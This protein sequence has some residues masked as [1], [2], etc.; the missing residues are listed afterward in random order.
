MVKQKSFLKQIQIDHCKVKEMHTCTKELCITD[1]MV[2]CTFDGTF[3]FQDYELST[4]ATQEILEKISTSV[5]IL[6]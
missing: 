2:I 3:K 6:K 1:A 4:I 5:I